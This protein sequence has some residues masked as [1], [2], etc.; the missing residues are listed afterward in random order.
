[1]QIRNQRLSQFRQRLI[2]L[3]QSCREELDPFF[4]DQPLIKGTLYPLRRKCSKASCRCARGEQHETIVLTASIGGKTR[5]WT[6]PEDRIEEIR[7]R[8]KLYREFRQARARFLKDWAKRQKEIL[9]VIDAIEKIR[10]QTP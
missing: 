4:S 8:T 9:L 1:M 5:L 3:G 10:T 7:Q 6:I 2:E